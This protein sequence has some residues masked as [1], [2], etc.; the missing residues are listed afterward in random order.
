[1]WVCLSRFE[2]AKLVMQWLC[3]H[4]DQNMQR[5]AVAIIS[6]L[7]AKVSSCSLCLRTGLTQRG[8]ISWEAPTKDSE[9]SIA[10]M[11]REMQCDRT[12]TGRCLRRSEEFICAAVMG[13]IS[14]LLLFFIKSFFHIN[15]I[16]LP[17]H[18]LKTVCEKGLFRKWRHHNPETA[19][20]ITHYTL[21]S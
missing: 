7:A 13:W 8:N 17:S 20:Q 14:V 6:I 16:K 15:N 12:E 9:N 4:E 11:H 19:S 10:M 2:A 21:C 18:S 1:M 3:N 5:M